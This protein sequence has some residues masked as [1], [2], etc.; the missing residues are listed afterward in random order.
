MPLLTQQNNVT[1]QLSTWASE[2]K[3]FRTAAAAAAAER[4]TVVDRTA[5]LRSTIPQLGVALR[6]A[7]DAWGQHTGMVRSLQQEKERLQDQY[8]KER[9]LLEE[10]AGKMEAVV[11]TEKQA[12][13]EFCREMEA[14]TRD[15]EEAMEEQEDKDLERLITI[16]S[17]QD[18]FGDATDAALQDA[19]EHLKNANEENQE[20]KQELAMCENELNALRVHAMKSHQPVR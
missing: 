1:E 8:N 14:L 4:K 5:Q 3:S 12:K 19:I 18:V 9:E 7:K 13:I 17:V 10:C 15:V 2:E 11:E 16:E 20:V 6:Q